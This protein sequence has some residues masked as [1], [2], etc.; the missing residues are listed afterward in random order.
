MMAKALNRYQRDPPV[1]PF[2]WHHG[3]ML[4]LG[5][6]GGALALTGTLNNRGQVVEL[7]FLAGDS[8]FHPFLWH[9]GGLSDLGTLGGDKGSANSLNH[10]GEVVG[11]AD[12]PG[13]QTHHAFLWRH[14]VIT[15]LGTQDGDPCSIAFSINSRGQIVGGSTDCSSSLHAFL[16]EQG[17]PMIDLN[18]FVPASSDLTLTEA[19]LINDRGE[20][21]VQGVLPNGDTHAVLLVPCDEEYGDREGCE[22]E[23]ASAGV[24]RLAPKS[25]SG[26]AAM[27]RL[28]AWLRMSRFRFPQADAGDRN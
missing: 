17:G 9:R 24:L 1:H 27:R 8:V 13:S 12:L 28:P 15:D 16:W 25:R 14:G 21:A 4:D 11:E 20:I 18:T 6:L 3:R 22:G 2:L 19:T 10:G 5:T 26:A 7:S 23:G